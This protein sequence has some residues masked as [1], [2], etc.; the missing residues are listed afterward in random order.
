[1]TEKVEIYECIGKGGRYRKIMT[2]KP[3]GQATVPAVFYQ[4]E[5]TGEVYWRYLPDFQQRMRLVCI[6]DD[7]GSRPVGWGCN[8][9]KPSTKP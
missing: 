7:N 9:P 8:P 1:M 3:A 2:A 6:Q 5:A 4:C